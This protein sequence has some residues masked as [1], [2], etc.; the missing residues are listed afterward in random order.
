MIGS[1][2]NKENVKVVPGAITVT[3]M[4]ALL[5]VMLLINCFRNNQ[6]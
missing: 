1:G 5:K 4:D 2:G 6:S 3:N